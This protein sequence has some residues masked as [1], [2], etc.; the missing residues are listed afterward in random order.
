[1]TFFATQMLDTKNTGQ[2]AL[3]IIINMMMSWGLIL[4]SI[5]HMK[6]L[7]RNIVKYRCRSS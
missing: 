5:T 3:R 7:S 4:K 2:T 1:M 6:V